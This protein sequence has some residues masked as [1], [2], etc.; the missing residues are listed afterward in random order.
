MQQ[1]HLD[2][3]L[4]KIDTLLKDADFSFRIAQTL[5]AA[6]YAGTGKEA[7]PFITPQ[8]TNEIV[9][10]SFKEEK[11]AINLAGFYALECGLTFLYITTKQSPV[12]LLTQIVNET[13]NT[14]TMLLL[15]RFANATWKAGQPFRGLDKIAR[16]VFTVASRLPEEEEKKDETQIIHAATKLLPALE[17]TSESPAEEQLK[18]LHSLLQNTSFAFEMAS[19]LEACYYTGQQQTPPPFLTAEEETATVNKKVKE[20]KI[21]TSI[22][23]FYALECGVNYLV[24]TRQI[25]PSTILKSIVNNSLSKDD[26]LLQTT[27]ANATWKAGQPFLSLTKTGDKNFTPFYFLSEAD[28]EKDW[29]QIKTAAAF[30]LK[31]LGV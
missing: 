13:C 7:P 22:A 20:I 18:A 10:K 28:I 19:W 5:A 14:E 2:Q 29:V 16:P 1:N 27:F 12:S 23:G 8:E 4:N 11:I 17:F 6:Y 21:A 15:K 9:S 24:T 3:E 25:L 30:L 26:K 31:E